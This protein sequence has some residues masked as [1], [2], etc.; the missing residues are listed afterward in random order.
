[1][2]KFDDPLDEVVHELLLERT[3]DLDGPRL[4]AFVDGWGCLMKLLEQTDLL[5]PGAPREIVAALEQ[6]VARIRGA[7][8][9]V[10]D[11]EN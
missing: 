9:R 7:Q 10:L 4:A 2:N 3:R 1:M 8:E 6:V 5:L 11:D